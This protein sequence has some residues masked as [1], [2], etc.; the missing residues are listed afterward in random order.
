MPTHFWVKN[1]TRSSYLLLWWNG[2]HASLRCWCLYGLEVQIL[3]G[4]PDWGNMKRVGCFRIPK[5]A[6]LSL[7]F[8]LNGLCEMINHVEEAVHGE[9][10]RKFRRENPGV[11]V[12]TFMRNP[13][14]RLVSAYSWIAQ[15]DTKVNLKAIEWKKH[16]DPYKSFEKFVT[17]EIGE[18]KG[19]G[20]MHLRTQHS[21]I[22]DNGKLMVDWV[23]KFE[24][25]QGDVARLC[26]KM[27]W[28]VVKLGKWNSS[29]GR[30]DYR[31]YYTQETAAIVAKAYEKDFELGGYS[32]QL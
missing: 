21:W 12:F 29:V 30:K 1:P 2:I 9:T 28:P 24:N 18:G 10:L 7:A 16:T 13:F 32:T 4:A 26:G 3:S 23:G 15:Q 25:L 20:V 17:S 14:D 6:S 31:G 19:L 11:F 27:G 22:S 5:T 8:A